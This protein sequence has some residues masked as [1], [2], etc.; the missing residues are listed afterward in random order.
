MVG[1]PN[2][3]VALVPIRGNI[4]IHFHLVIDGLLPSVRLGWA[5]E[6]AKYQEKATNK[7][8]GMFFHVFLNFC[9]KIKQIK[10]VAKPFILDTGC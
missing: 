8:K 6:A 3:L 10:A 4:H 5:F 2:D 1:I 7:K 9:S